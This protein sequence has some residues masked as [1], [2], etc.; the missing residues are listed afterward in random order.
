MLRI[1]TISWSTLA[2]I[3][4]VVVGASVVVVVGASVVVT[5]TGD[6][7]AAEMV[8]SE[9]TVFSFKSVISVGNCHSTV[10]G[11]VTTSSPKNN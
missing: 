8:V 1:K 5:I 3:S 10:V 2:K 4:C 7:V 6:V 11:N 9:P